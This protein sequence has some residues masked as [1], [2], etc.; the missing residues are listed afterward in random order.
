[1]PALHMTH[2]LDSVLKVAVRHQ[3]DAKQD[4]ADL[5]QGHKYDSSP[6]RNLIKTKA[7][8]CFLHALHVCIILQIMTAWCCLHQALRSFGNYGKASQYSG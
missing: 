7:C 4:C 6:Q 8:L 2:S 1:M 5:S 3:E